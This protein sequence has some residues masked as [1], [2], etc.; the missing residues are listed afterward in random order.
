M[1]CFQGRELTA[2]GRINRTVTKTWYE[3]TIGTVFDVKTRNTH[4]KPLSHDVNIF[5]AHTQRTPFYVRTEE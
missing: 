1:V 5:L 3:A 4:R 2:I